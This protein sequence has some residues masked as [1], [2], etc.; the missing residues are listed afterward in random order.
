VVLK[1]GVHAIANATPTLPLVDVDLLVEEKNV[2]ALVDALAAAGFGNPARKL[3]HH[4][5]LTPSKGR[6]SIEVHWTTHDDGTQLDPATWSRLR[7]IEAA[8]PLQR[9]GAADNLLHLIEHAILVHRD[10]SVSIRDTILI[11]IAAKDCT[12]RELQTVRSALGDAEQ[13][14]AMNSLLEFAGALAD[15]NGAEDPFTQ[16][17]ATFYSAVVLAPLVPRALSSSGAMAFALELELGRISRITAVRNSLRWRGTGNKRLSSIADR[18]PFIGHFVLAPAHLA[19]Y[20]TYAALTIPSIRAT[21]DR[22]LSAL[23]R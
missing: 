14:E 2:A 12:E 18:L 15:Q 22:A 21:R 11:G 8:K 10:R 17:C 23:G 1:G 4:Q 13:S 3:L 20:A 9:L 19:Y 5:G 16:S 6:L 7:P